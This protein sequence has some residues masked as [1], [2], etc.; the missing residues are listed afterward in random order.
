MNGN[1]DSDGCQDNPQPNGNTHQQNTV[2]DRKPHH[3]NG[4]NLCA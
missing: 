2:A 1:A 3:R 4:E